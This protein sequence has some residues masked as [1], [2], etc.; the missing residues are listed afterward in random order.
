MQYSLISTACVLKNSAGGQSKHHVGQ[1]LTHTT[2]PKLPITLF[3]FFTSHFFP[4]S[5][6]APVCCMSANDSCLSCV[7]M[8]VLR[9]SEILPALTWCAAISG[10]HQLRHTFAVTSSYCLALIL[11]RAPVGLDLKR[12]S[13]VTI[14]LC[15]NSE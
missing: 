1:I 8:P 13:A 4:S 11:P 5:S 2:R 7:Q 10:G 3:F 14:K 9:A 12:T 6:F 15:R